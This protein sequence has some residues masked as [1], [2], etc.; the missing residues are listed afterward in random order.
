MF[1]H[2]GRSLEVSGRLVVEAQDGGL[3]VLGRD[4]VLWAIPPNEQVEHTADQRAFQPYNRDEL[5]KLL[6]ADLPGGFRVHPTTHYLIFH[7][8]SP[9]YA[10]WC[11][12]LFEQL[13]KAFSN[14]WTRRGFQLRPPEFPLVAVLFAD[15]ASYAKYA[16]PELGDASESILGYFGMTSNRMTMYDLTGLESQGR[17]AARTRTAAQ[18]S[19]ILAQPDAARTVATIVHEATHQIAFNCGLHPRLSD[20]PLWFSEGIATYFETP[21]L[22]SAKGWGGLGGLN[23]M[24]FEQFREYLKSRP[25]DSLVTLVRDDRRF[26][27]PKLA[28]DAYAEAWALTYFLLQK[29][30][31]EYLG[32]MAT[33]SKKKPLLQDGPER[34]VDQFRQAFG[35]PKLL[36]AEFLRYMARLR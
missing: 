14:C 22:R 27:N 6:L 33:L 8:T 31:K 28:L 10:Q 2:D 20:C 35:D 1:K 21:D 18:I 30:S 4:G 23:Q 13:Y 26:R 32:Y 29:H 15:K 17:G 12:A 16:R 11:G 24:R 36:D 25:A 7:N 19:Q 3:L 9:A 34:R 5:S